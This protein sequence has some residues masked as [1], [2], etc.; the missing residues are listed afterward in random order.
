MTPAPSRPDITGH[1]LF[2]DGDLTI[3][4]QEDLAAHVARVAREH[5][6]AELR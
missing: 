6:E 4:L 3:Q 5:P 1:A 2:A